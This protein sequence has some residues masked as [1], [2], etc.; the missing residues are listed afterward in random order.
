MQKLVLK[1]QDKEIKEIEILSM[2]KLM[3]YENEVF[4]HNL[5]SLYKILGELGN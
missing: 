3:K 1:S 2:N 5:E 4:G